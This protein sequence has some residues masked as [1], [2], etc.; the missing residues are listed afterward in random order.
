M[1]SRDLFLMAVVSVF[2]FVPTGIVA[3]VH[4]LNVEPALN[5]GDQSLAVKEASQVKKWCKISLFVGVPVYVIVGLLLIVMI[6]IGMCLTPSGFEKTINDFEDVAITHAVNVIREAGVDATSGQRAVDQ[7]VAE[8][9]DKELAYRMSLKGATPT[10]IRRLKDQL[11]LQF[12]KI[13][14]DQRVDG[15]RYAIHELIRMN[16]L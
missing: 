16:G 10:E 4:S 7:I 11:L 13:P 5:H 8:L 12:Q 9:I 14:E 2:L 6:V 1:K 15:A 3:L